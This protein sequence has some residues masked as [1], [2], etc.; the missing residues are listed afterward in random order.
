MFGASIGR[1]GQS[2]ID[3]MVRWLA[4]GH[5]NP[6]ILTLVGV[7]INVGSGLLFGFGYF[8]GRH[9]PIVAICSTCSMDKWRV[10]RPVT[11]FGGFWIRRSTAFRHGGFCDN[12]LLRARY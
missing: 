10:V 4:H 7:S 11:R 3:A 6:N 2:I 8:F 1:A 12:G 9:C 5:I